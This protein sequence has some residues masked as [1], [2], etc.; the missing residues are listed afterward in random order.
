MIHKE[1]ACKN[2]FLVYVFIKF[3]FRTASS[4]EFK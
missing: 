4:A 3:E 2:R 1:F